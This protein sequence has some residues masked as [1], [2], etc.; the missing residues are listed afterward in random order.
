MA[1]QDL[2]VRSMCARGP[3]RTRGVKIMAA[4]AATPHRVAWMLRDCSCVLS[5]GVGFRAGGKPS[6]TWK[7]KSYLRG[8]RPACLRLSTVCGKVSG[9][10]EMSNLDR[11][12]IY[13]LCSPLWEP[14]LIESVVQKYLT[15]WSILE[16]LDEG[17]EESVYW[18]LYTLN[19]LINSNKGRL[20]LDYLTSSCGGLEFSFV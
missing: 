20:M 10:Y 18:F 19:F 7:T 15:R 3:T 9:E 1:P 4:R 11:S 14:M 17:R 8:D 5:R 16:S 12:T 2:G 13:L 6:A